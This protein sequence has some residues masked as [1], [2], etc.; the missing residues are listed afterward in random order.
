[1]EKI[2]S[3]FSSDVTQLLGLDSLIHGGSWYKHVGCPQT[4]AAAAAAGR[5]W[6]QLCQIK[7]CRQTEQSKD[8]R[9]KT[10]GHFLLHIWPA[11]TKIADLFNTLTCTVTFSK[12]QVEVKLRIVALKEQWLKTGSWLA[13]HPDS[14]TSDTN[15]S[16]IKPLSRLDLLFTLITLEKSKVENIRITAS[17]F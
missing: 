17:H 16:P 8:I 7:G 11:L 5:C 14:L 10:R 13:L 4:A 1:M 6:R 2:F 9:G 3:G 12:P 15:K